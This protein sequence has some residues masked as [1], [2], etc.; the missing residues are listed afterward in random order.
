MAKHLTRHGMEAIRRKIAGLE[1]RRLE[2]LQHAGEAAQND[3]NAYHDNFSYEESMRQQELFSR[4]MR[5]LWD[6]LQ[7][8]EEVP[9]PQDTARVSLGHLV[10]VEY[11]DGSR[12]EL[13]VCGD[14]EGSVFDNGCSAS[15][16]LGRVLLGMQ[17]GESRPVTVGPRTFG[18]KVC[19]IHLGSPDLLEGQP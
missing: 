5:S 12:E 3:P 4:Q 2:A 9:P 16:P 11:E 6:I 1:A 19:R 14:G 17:R 10:T 8:A 7:G 13:F 15:S 18:V